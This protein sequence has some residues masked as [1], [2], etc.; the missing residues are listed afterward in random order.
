MKML[1]CKLSTKYGSKLVLTSCMVLWTSLVFLTAFFSDIY[2]LSFFRFL[3]G[4]AS[5]VVMPAIFHCLSV[6]LS[7]EERYSAFNSVQT[8][9]TAGQLL[10]SL[11]APLLSWTSC[12]VLFSLLGMIWVFSWFTFN[13][14]CPDTLLDVNLLSQHHL[15]TDLGVPINGV[16]WS[17]FMKQPALWAVYCSHFCSNWTLIIVIT[18][19]PIYLRNFFGIQSVKPLLLVTPFFFRTLCDF[20]VAKAPNLPLTTGKLDPISSKRLSSTLA[21]FLCGL[22]ILLFGLSTTPTKSMLFLSLALSVL[23]LNTVSKMSSFADVSQGHASYPFMISNSLAL[24]PGLFLGPLTAF[25]VTESGGRW[26]PTFIL[27]SVV[28]VVGAF[29]YYVESRGVSELP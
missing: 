15:G 12:F 22:F 6:Q 5:G 18:W 16:H 27:T 3:T 13:K 1:G 29:I 2:L 26:F 9:F 19:L 7:P 14:R 28:N 21:L 11:F 10:A 23:C 25:L 24:V 8:F 20:L 4:T 17:H